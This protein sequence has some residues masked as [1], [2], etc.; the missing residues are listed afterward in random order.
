MITYHPGRQ[1]KLD[2]LSRRSYLVPK[3]GDVVYNQ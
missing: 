2:A 1:G 3:E